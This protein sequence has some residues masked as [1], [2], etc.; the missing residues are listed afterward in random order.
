MHVSFRLSF[1]PSFLLPFSFLAP[2]PKSG[3]TI[4]KEN[5]KTHPKDSPFLKKSEGIRG[6]LN[7]TYHLEKLSKLSH[8]LDETVW[9]S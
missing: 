1:P 8:I 3:K 7:A 4:A 5:W 6:H 9:R 2:K